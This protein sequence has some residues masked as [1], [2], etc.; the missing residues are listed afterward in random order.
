[1]SETQLEKCLECVVNIF[2]QYSSRV[3]H[4]DVLSKGELRKLIEQQLPNFLK[5]KK[6][7]ASIDR[8]FE[9]LDK[10]KDEQVSFDEFIS[11]LCRVLI[12]THENIHQGQGDSP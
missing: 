6:D 2:H 4:F 3:G 10:D 9:E 5:N 8:I 12:A 1:M 11:F 7:P